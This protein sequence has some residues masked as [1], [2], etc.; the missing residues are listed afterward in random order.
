MDKGTKTILGLGFLAFLGWWLFGNKAIISS[1]QNTPPIESPKETEAQHFSEKKYKIK[2][3]IFFRDQDGNFLFV[4]PKDTIVV[5]NGDIGGNIYIKTEN[6]SVTL[7]DEQYE[8]VPSYT[9]TSQKNS[10]GCLSY[11]VI[12]NS[13]IPLDSDGQPIHSTSDIHFVNCEGEPN[14][15]TISTNSEPTIIHNVIED[16]MVSGDTDVSITKI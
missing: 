11:E 8:S 7:S 12:N 9:A 3:D 5:G 4:I 10:L 1:T 6:G 13:E 16:S 14:M 2:E 15:A